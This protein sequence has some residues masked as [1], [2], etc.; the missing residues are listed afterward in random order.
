MPIIRLDEITHGNSIA[1]GSVK[2]ITIPT[3]LLVQTFIPAGK[4]CF[5]FQW[6]WLGIQTTDP[7]IYLHLPT[8]LTLRQGKSLPSYARWTALTELKSNTPQG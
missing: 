7:G 6:M 2:S 5:E 8:T 1:Q 4:G 3:R